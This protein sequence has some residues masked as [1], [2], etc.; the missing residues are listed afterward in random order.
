M[1]DKTI[2][3]DITEANKAKKYSDNGL[4]QIESFK[5]VEEILKEHCVG[6]NAKNIVD[7]R[8]HDTIFIDGARGVGKTAFMLNIKTFYENKKNNK[9]YLFLDPVDPTLL[10][11]TEKFLSVVFA[12]IVERVSDDID[13]VN[14]DKSCKYFEALSSLSKSLSAIKTLSN[15]IGIEEIASNKS[16][17]KLEQNAHKF[18]QVVSEMYEVEGIVI[19]IDDI[20]MAFEKGFDVLEVVRKYLASPYLIPVVAGDMELYKEIVETQFMNKICF[21]DDVKYLQSKCSE[22]MPLRDSE[23]YKAKRALLDNLVEQYLHKL[24]PSEYHIEL[25]DIFSILKSNKV[26]I[27]FENDLKVSFSDLED[28][29]IRHINF[30]INQA[31]YVFDVFVN[32]ARELIQYIYAKKKIYQKFFEKSSTEFTYKEYETKR[33]MENMDEDIKN[34]IK[35]P[36]YKESLAITALKY[37]I[38]KGKFKELSKLT[39][40][41]SNSFE[42]EEYNIYKSFTSDFF[43]AFRRIDGSIIAEEK[44]I[45]R[46]VIQSKN[47]NEFM[48]GKEHNDE[49]F[50]TSLFVFNDYYTQHQTKNYLFSGK[51]IEMLIFSFSIKERVKIE[52]RTAGEIVGLNDSYSFEDYC[53]GVVPDYD[54]IY[55]R[56]REDI[57]ID[58][59][60]IKENSTL[61]KIATKVPFNSEFTKKRYLENDYDDS[62]D[63]SDDEIIVPMETEK[64]YED[65]A[66]WKC[67]Y[68]RDGLNLNTLS[69]FKIILKFFKNYGEV[70]PL[71]L[72]DTPLAFMQRTVLIFINAVAYFENSNLDVANTNMAV[73]KKFDFTNI[74]TKT[75]ASTKNIKPMFNQQGSLT[76]ALFFHPLVLRILFPNENSSLDLLRF[77][78]QKDIKIECLQYLKKKG[79]SPIIQ[80]KKVREI[81]KKMKDEVINNQISLKTFSDCPEFTKLISKGYKSE[82]YKELRDYFRKILKNYNLNA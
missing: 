36:E 28:F 58:T 79:Y 45:D 68:I 30:G 57:E 3:I 42:N 31:A 25:K 35:K 80:E 23:E 37:K 44:K 61:F 69:L 34:F 41:A 19:L 4:F 54:L 16:S 33:V 62:D 2:I 55:S 43:T 82:E 10:E 15:D 71:E 65:I 26:E 13:S 74:L 1:N 52:E 60:G 38:N 7:C 18:F 8:F 72:E 64:I 5:K 59:S 9:R 81:L 20:D 29:E 75:N 51:F 40:N 14:E 21:H 77:N 46:L 66:I 56:D 32:N 73:A 49:K 47:L 22:A 53:K 67:L 63:D 50:I 11:H 6:S 27:H 70:K 76:R 48:R 12:K 78:N 24:F 17:L 39:Q